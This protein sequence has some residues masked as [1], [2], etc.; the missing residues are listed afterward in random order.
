MACGILVLQPRVKPTPPAMEAQSLNHWTTREAPKI[1]FLRRKIK[2]DQA[3]CQKIKSD[4]AL[5]H[6]SRCVSENLL[7]PVSI[8]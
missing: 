4:L 8:K 7:K 6:K 5:L 2:P 1:I 3:G